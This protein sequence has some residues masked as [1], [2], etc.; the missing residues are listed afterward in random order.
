MVHCK[1]SLSAMNPSNNSTASN[2]P[3]GHWQN[4]VSSSRHGKVPSFCRFVASP[5]SSTYF[6]QLKKTPSCQKI[7]D[8]VGCWNGRKFGKHMETPSCQ[9]MW[10]HHST[11]SHMKRHVLGNKVSCSDS[12]SFQ[13]GIH[14]AIVTIPGNSIV[15]DEVHSIGP[16]KRDDL[17]QVT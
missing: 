4:T 7:W 11:H 10:F 17:C 9:K 6:R 1:S 16:Y 3:L 2:R 12:L 13:C 8:G 15:V 5:L 14:S